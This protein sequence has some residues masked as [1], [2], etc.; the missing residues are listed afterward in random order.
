MLYMFSMRFLFHRLLPGAAAL[1]AFPLLGASSLGE[2]P[3]AFLRAHADSPVRWEPWAPAAFAR[4]RAEGKPLFVVIGG[5][6]LELSRAMREQTFARAE[7]AEQLNQEFV[8]V[9]VDR[10]EQPS[11]AALHETYV[12]AVKQQ[13]GWPLNVW[14]TPE[15]KPFDGAAY[16]PPSEEWGTEG[17]PTV[18]TRVAAAWVADPD[19]QRRNAEEAVKL[20][21]EL[22]RPPM[23]PTASP[24]K[25]QELLTNE[26]ATYLRLFEP[27]PAGFGE[28]PRYPEPELLRFLL[29]GNEA[30][31]ETAKLALAKLATGTLRDPV[32]GGF[33]RNTVDDEGKQPYLQKALADQARLALAFLDL[34]AI[35]EDAQWSDVVRGALEYA[36]G[37]GDP[38]HGFAAMEDATR[39]DVA[40]YYFWS[41]DEI[42]QVLGAAA[43]AHVRRV[44]GVTEEGN[45]PADA[46]L[47]LEPEKENLLYWNGPIGSDFSRDDLAAAIEKLRA[48]RAERVQPLRDSRA[49]SGAHGLLL[50]ALARAGTELSE[51]RFADAAGQLA[52]FI[53]RE[54]RFDDGRLRQRYGSAHEAAPGGYAWVIRGLL[55]YGDTQG[56]GSTRELAQGLGERMAA[57]YADSASGHFFA[58]PSPAPAGAWGRVHVPA[59]DRGG[60]P[61]AECVALMIS[62]TNPGAMEMN[63]DQMASAIVSEIEN[64]FEMA[65]GDQLLA[66][67][68]FLSTR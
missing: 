29:R 27:V 59:P 13:R 34:A 65:R 9:L 12:R 42:D 60:M 17:F 25:V 45:L 14:L 33:F 58:V 28:P 50:T 15:G 24:V 46:F 63:P 48:H 35:D 6:E 67:Q 18:S 47:D 41:A 20:V 8:C 40:P 23:A 22:D 19:A 68:T 21:A 66:L 1:L 44:F 37:L 51:P 4:A 3:S 7:V 36:L 5:F 64:G 11:V 10:D 16:L 26:T 38:T 30:E 54:L 2:A 39:K 62:A 61:S 57:A 32:D 52:G 43:G 56:D 55:L 53:E 49:T 31:R